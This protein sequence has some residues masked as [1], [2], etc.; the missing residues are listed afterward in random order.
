MANPKENIDIKQELNNYQGSYKSQSSEEEEEE[1]AFI[2]EDKVRTVIEED[3]DTT[4]VPAKILNPI[5]EKKYKD[6][7]NINLAKL[8][9]T[10]TIITAIVGIV[11][12]VISYTRK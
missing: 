2:D 1:V 9:N 3:F 6:K 7:L 12:M 4:P 11:A 10:T 5:K 8:G